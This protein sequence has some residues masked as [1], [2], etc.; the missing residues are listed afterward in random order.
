[1]FPELG[2]RSRVL[3]KHILLASPIYV[4]D[5]LT[6]RCASSSAGAGA[7]VGVDVERMALQWMA[8]V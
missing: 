3:A 7:G 6:R 1:M 2:M 5:G 4:P 8:F